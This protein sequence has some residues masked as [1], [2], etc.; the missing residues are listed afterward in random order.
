MEAKAGLVLTKDPCPFA[1]QG[2][3]RWARLQEHEIKTS[4][5][6]NYSLQLTNK[7]IFTDTVSAERG[8]VYPLWTWRRKLRLR[9][10]ATNS[11]S[12][13]KFMVELGFG[14]KEFHSGPGVR[15]VI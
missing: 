8:W 4:E 13:R 7:S 6:C 9:G 5:T 11:R 12:H 14:F 1:L 2:L 15:G 3:P 10:K